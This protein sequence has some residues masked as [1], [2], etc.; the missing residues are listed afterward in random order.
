MSR[1]QIFYINQLF[2]LNGIS[3]NFDAGFDA[4][5]LRKKA[6]NF[7]IIA[8]IPNNKKTHKYIMIIILIIN[9]TKNDML[10]KEQ[11][12]Y[13]ISSDQYLKGLTLQ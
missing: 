1:S 11:M 5:N 6:F 3:L 10:S 12:P 9:Y 4:E 8:N 2:P 7:G 13:W